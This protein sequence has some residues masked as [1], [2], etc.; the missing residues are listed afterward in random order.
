M[1]TLPHSLTQN[2]CDFCY[3]TVSLASVKIT[4]LLAETFYVS[5]V[6]DSHCQK[7]SQNYYPNLREENRAVEITEIFRKAQHGSCNWG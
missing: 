7:G 4:D 2:Q 5:S 3:S 6:G 1:S